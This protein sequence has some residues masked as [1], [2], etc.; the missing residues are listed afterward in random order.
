MV[1]EPRI[2]HHALTAPRGRPG[3]ARW[4]R[5]ARA[6]WRI[7]V[8][9]LILLPLVAS[10]YVPDDFLV[11]VRVN[12]QGDFGITYSG[13]LTWAP[14]WADIR[15]GAL[16]PDEI[17]E[18]VENI[19]R[20]LERYPEFSTVEHEGAGRFRVFYETT[21]HVDGDESFYFLRGN[22]RI[23]AILSREDGLLVVR[24]HA[25]TDDNRQRLQAVGMDMRG[26][27][28]VATDRP[29][30][31]HNAQARADGPQGFVYYDWVIRS[32]NDPAPRIV[33][34]R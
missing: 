28:R 25:I 17:A 10:C 18:K 26:K 5:R 4:G 29:V 11:E 8:T 13:T 1:R 23:I 33:M 31:S 34:A 16:S 27:M 30:L 12:R 2:T 32:L 14:L 20:D 6:W 9:G 21:G 15:K 7:L 22:A 24:T 3:P 19:R